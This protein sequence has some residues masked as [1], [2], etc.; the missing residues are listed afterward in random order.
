MLRSD[1]AGTSRPTT[2]SSDSTM[3]LLSSSGEEQPDMPEDA[4]PLDADD[5]GSEQQPFLWEQI[6]ESIDPVELEEIRRVVGDAL[7]SACSDVYAEVRALQEIL[8]DY[9]AG[10]DEL[11]KRRTAVPRSLGSQPAGLV[12]MELKSLV[13]QLRKRAAAVAGSER[14]KT[15]PCS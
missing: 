11:V 9:S 5:G 8:A 10:T 7:V 2:A 4:G 15:R 14:V 6:S 3:P 12:Q 1:F 13:T